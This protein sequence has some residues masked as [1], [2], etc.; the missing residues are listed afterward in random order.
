MNVL[1]LSLHALREKCSGNLMEQVK[2]GTLDEC[3]GYFLNQSS[4]ILY[5]NSVSA[6][7]SLS[8]IDPGSSDQFIVPPIDSSCQRRVTN[9]ATA[10]VRAAAFANN[11][12]FNSTFPVGEIGRIIVDLYTLNHFSDKLDDPITSLNQD[13]CPFINVTLR[14]LLQD[15]VNIENQLFGQFMF[16]N[17]KNE[18]YSQQSVQSPFK[19]LQKCKQAADNTPSFQTQIFKQGIVQMLMNE[20][21]TR[22]SSDNRILNQIL[23]QDFPSTMKNSLFIN[24]VND[25]KNDVFN[26]QKFLQ[27][28][29]FQKTVKRFRNDTVTVSGIYNLYTNMNDLSGLIQQILFDGNNYEMHQIKETNTTSYQ[30]FTCQQLDVQMSYRAMRALFKPAH[31]QLNRDARASQNQIGFKE[32]NVHGTKFYIMEAQHLGFYTAMGFYFSRNISFGFAL[33]VNADDDQLLYELLEY[34]RVFGVT[35]TDLSEYRISPVDQAF[36]KLKYAQIPKKSYLNYFLGLYTN[37]EIYNYVEYRSGLFA[38]E[39]PGLIQYNFVQDG[40]Y[41]YSASGAFYVEGNETVTTYFVFFGL[42]VVLNCIIFILVIMRKD[43]TI[44]QNLYQTLRILPKTTRESLSNKY[45]SY[46]FWF[47]KKQKVEN[48]DDDDIKSVKK[49]IIIKP[50]FLNWSILLATAVKLVAMIIQISLIFASLSKSEP[51]TPVI[52]LSMI[53][54]SNTISTIVSF[55]WIWLTS[56]IIQTL[57]FIFEMSTK[58]CSF[59]WTWIFVG[60]FSFGLDVSLFTFMCKSQLMNNVE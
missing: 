30:Q 4:L 55:G 2:L 41:L 46:G 20:P 16:M 37:P 8:V 28:N 3:L 26:N 5:N 13:L 17:S 49:T 24:D 10:G 33:N 12:S 40:N 34:L 52:Q 19:L 36:K 14:Q 25:F 53:N 22:D 1:I 11:H 15:Q 58:V 27:P 35:T 60:T 42:T 45:I 6:S 48:D 56:F 23:Q 43:L 54:S 21:I 32:I 9:R 59:T 57:I 47:C 38:P 7:I 51:D 31:S 50:K 44:G 18:K 29:T 39:I